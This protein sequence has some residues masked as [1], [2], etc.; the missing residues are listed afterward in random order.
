M[1][2]IIHDLGITN[3]VITLLFG[4]ALL[5]YLIPISLGYALFLPLNALLLWGVINRKR[6]AIYAQISILITLVIISAFFTAF[7]PFT[8][9]YATPDQLYDAQLRLGILTYVYREFVS[10]L[11]FLPIWGFAPG[12]I[13]LPI[14]YGINFLSDYYD[15]DLSKFSLI[16]VGPLTLTLSLIFLLIV[17][18]YWW[19]RG[20]DAVE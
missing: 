15:L 19:S 1:R 9:I 4:L 10:L 3:I 18:K 14:G 13:V 17:V 5:Q 12:F 11:S 20:G 7:I 16:V 8:E 6:I 2:T